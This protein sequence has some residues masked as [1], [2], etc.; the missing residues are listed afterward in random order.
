MSLSLFFARWLFKIP[1]LLFVLHLL[2]RKVSGKQKQILFAEVLASR[3]PF[4]F[5]PGAAWN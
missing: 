2:K 1:G 5:R 4:S 3:V